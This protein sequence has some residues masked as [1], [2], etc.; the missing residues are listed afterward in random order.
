MIKHL[1]VQIEELP[2]G[3][4][5]A[6][7]QDLPTSSHTRRLLPKLLRMPRMSR[8]NLSI[9]IWNM[10]IRALGMSENWK[11]FTAK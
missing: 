2:E 6:T 8:R 1:L 7:S 10:V 11:A 5:M 4:F 9:L 3:G